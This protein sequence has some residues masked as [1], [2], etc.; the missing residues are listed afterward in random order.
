MNITWSKIFD[1]SHNKRQK[2]FYTIDII[3]LLIYIKNE[4]NIS[5]IKNFSIIKKEFSQNFFVFINIYVMTYKNFIKLFLFYYS[6]DL[7]H[8]FLYDFHQNTHIFGIFHTW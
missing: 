8:T 4:K 7:N 6:Y 2:Y 3:F 1:L 5:H